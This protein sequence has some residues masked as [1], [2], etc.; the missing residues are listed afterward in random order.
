VKN[1]CKSD[2]YNIFEIYVQSINLK[3]NWLCWECVA[4]NSL[5]CKE[6]YNVK[7]LKSYEL[8]KL[9]VSLLVYNTNS[10]TDIGDRMHPV[11]FSLGC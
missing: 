6:V 5:N 8:L 11:R 9:Q 3:Q 2:V 4:S 7:Y 10:A 1:V